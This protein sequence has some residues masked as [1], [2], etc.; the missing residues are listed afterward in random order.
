MRS[1]AGSHDGHP[2]CYSL[3]DVTTRGSA[4]KP[5][6]ALQDPNNQLRLQPPPASCA[7]PR[8]HHP[9][10][11]AGTDGLAAEP[12][13]QHPLA[14]SPDSSSVSQVKNMGRPA[15]GPAQQSS[16]KSWQVPVQAALQHSPGS[17][18][19]CRM[20]A[21]SSWPCMSGRVC[22]LSINCMKVSPGVS[23]RCCTSGQRQHQGAGQCKPPVH[24]ARVRCLQVGGV[25][26]CNTIVWTSIRAVLSL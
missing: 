21:V 15:Q 3:G 12:L 5:C 25:L 9:R 7:A 19:G 6:Q 24:A 23:C 10:S 11:P 26:C 18:R 8:G 1:S 2:A 13:N 20:H 16:Q 14:V 22:P 17:C 4:C